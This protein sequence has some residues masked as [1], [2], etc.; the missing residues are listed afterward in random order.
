MV[1]GSTSPI[2]AGPGRRGMVSAFPLG[3]PHAGPCWCLLQDTQS[4]SDG[5]DGSNGSNSP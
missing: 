5:S 3:L 2:E 1:A 4:A